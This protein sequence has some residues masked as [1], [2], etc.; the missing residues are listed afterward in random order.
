MSRRPHRARIVQG[1]ISPMAMKLRRRIPRIRR[2][3]PA[4][5][6]RWALARRVR[7]ARAL[8]WGMQ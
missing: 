4:L 5:P 3:F 2:R 8:N 7:R 6:P 1:L